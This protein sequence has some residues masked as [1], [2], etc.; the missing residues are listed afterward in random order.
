MV[1]NFRFKCHRGLLPSVLMGITGV[2]DIAMSLCVSQLVIP[3]STDLWCYFT[4]RNSICQAEAD[5]TDGAHA[6]QRV[7]SSSR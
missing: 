7:S 6:E 2:M 5:Q 4:L 1:L 3:F